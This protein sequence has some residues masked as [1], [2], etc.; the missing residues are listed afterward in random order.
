V[1]ETVACLHIIR[2]RKFLEEIASLDKIEESA[3]VLAA[4][5]H[6]LR[7][8]LKPN[9]QVKETESLYNVDEI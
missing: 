8:S 3:R 7:N 9:H 5:L 6:A 1:L 4:K 2:R